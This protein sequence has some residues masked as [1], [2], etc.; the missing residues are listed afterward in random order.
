MTIICLFLL[1]NASVAFC[2]V[3]MMKVMLNSVWA[4]LRENRVELD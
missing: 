1:I 3:S 2:G 4:Y